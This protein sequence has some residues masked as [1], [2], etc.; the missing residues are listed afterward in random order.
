MWADGFGQLVGE[1]KQNAHLA[2]AMQNTHFKQLQTT[3]PI[4]YPKKYIPMSWSLR[5][6]HKHP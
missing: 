2:V 1:V 4:T 3:F 6:I 5:P